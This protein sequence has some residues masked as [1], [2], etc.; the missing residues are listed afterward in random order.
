MSNRD[1]D[2]HKKREQGEHNSSQ[3]NLTLNIRNSFEKAVH[4]VSDVLG[5]AQNEIVLRAT[6]A[7]VAAQYVASIS[8]ALAAQYARGREIVLARENKG[9]STVDLTDLPAAQRKAV[10]TYQRLHSDLPS[11]IPFYNKEI[12]ARDL[13]RDIVRKASQQNPSLKI[14]QPANPPASRERTAKVAVAKAKV[15]ESANDKGSRPLSSELSSN[16]LTKSQHTQAAKTNKHLESVRAVSSPTIRN[17]SK[18]SIKSERNERNEKN[19]KNENVIRNTELGKSF[20]KYTDKTTVINALQDNVVKAR[21]VSAP[22]NALISALESKPVDRLSKSS[23]SLVKTSDNPAVEQRRPEQIVGKTEISEKKSYKEACKEPYETLS[24]AQAVSAESTKINQ[25]KISKTLEA[26]FQ[27]LQIEREQL[28]SLTEKFA[29]PSAKGANELAWCISSP[30]EPQLATDGK[31]DG[32]ISLNEHMDTGRIIDSS[33]RSHSANEEGERHLNLRLIWA[34]QSKI[35]GAIQ[36]E[37]L[38]VRRSL[39]LDLTA[40]ATYINIKLQPELAVCLRTSMRT[41]GLPDQ[42]FVVNETKTIRRALSANCDDCTKTESKSRPGAGIKTKSDIGIK[43][44][45][46]SKSKADKTAG[47]TYIAH[48]RIG[49]KQSFKPIDRKHDKAEGLPLKVDLASKQPIGDSTIR[50]TGEAKVSS[51]EYKFTCSD[52]NQKYLSGPE[53][54][55][56]AIIALAGAAK[57]RPE[58]SALQNESVA[59]VQKYNLDFIGDQPNL[60]GSIAATESNKATKSKSTAIFIRPKVLIGVGDTLV[61]IA[62]QLFNDAGIAWLILGINDGIEWLVLEGKTIVKLRSRQEIFIPVYQDIIDFQKVRTKEMTGQ[63][64]ITIVEENRIDREIL[65]ITMAPMAG[66]SENSD[67][68]QDWQIASLQIGDLD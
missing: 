54:A 43:S 17:E 19:K 46:K 14:D 1:N 65:N 2:F 30:N 66:S 62:E 44:D 53:I 39:E 16:A 49:S 68:L 24:A 41:P 47:E 22:G 33:E 34:G 38:K 37:S 55:L 63:N 25:P 59:V 27:V 31:E 23:N 61:A 58:A 21:G 15:T 40:D 10:E 42:E 26:P 4:Q 60:S 20:V 67:P 13:D 8:P 5:K 35:I 12:L 18:S 45:T 64:L 32:L 36:C 3:E 50:A 57:L 6:G 56:A 28:T 7:P 52:K 48:V 29:T 51:R 9:K 11:K